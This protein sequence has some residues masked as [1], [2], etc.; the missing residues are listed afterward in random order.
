[1][2]RCGQRLRVSRVAKTWSWSGTGINHLEG[3]ASLDGGASPEPRKPIYMSIP[4]NRHKIRETAVFQSEDI[5]GLRPMKLTPHRWMG[6][7]PILVVVNP[8]R[9]NLAIQMRR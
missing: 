8:P 2:P 4:W 3:W 6:L 9:G 7:I 5:A 1:M